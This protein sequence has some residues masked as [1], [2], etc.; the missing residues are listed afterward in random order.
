MST[1][2]LLEKLKSKKII[3]QIGVT[4]KIQRTI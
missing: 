4:L 1:L 2:E 3:K